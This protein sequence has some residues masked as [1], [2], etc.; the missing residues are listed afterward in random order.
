MKLSVLVLFL[1]LVFCFM[2]IPNPTL[3]ADSDADVAVV[4]IKAI[5]R[6]WQTLI[7]KQSLLLGGCG[8]FG[9]L[10][11]RWQAIRLSA[12]STVSFDVKKTDSLVSPYVGII[13]IEGTV[14]MNGEQVNPEGAIFPLVQSCFPTTQQALADLEFKAPFG[15]RE[16]VASYNFNDGSFVLAGG[17][18]QFQNTVVPVL[19]A[20]IQ[21]GLASVAGLMGVSIRK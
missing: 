17:N 5:A 21:L 14:E 4:E 8:L 2:W 19:N 13:Q 6:S 18:E 15:L 20:S 9:T 11:G 7:Q 3:A 16:Y 1:L 12:D 10:N